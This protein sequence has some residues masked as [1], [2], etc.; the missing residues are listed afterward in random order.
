MFGGVKSYIPDSE[1]VPEQSP[2]L[3]GPLARRPPCQQPNEP[4]VFSENHVA[5]HSEIENTSENDAVTVVL[6][7]AMKDDPGRAPTSELGKRVII[8]WMATVGL[9]IRYL[10]VG[11]CGSSYRTGVLAL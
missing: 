1:G 2:Y 4:S 8:R 3:Q 10:V 11:R 5:S 6:G 7:V 9:M